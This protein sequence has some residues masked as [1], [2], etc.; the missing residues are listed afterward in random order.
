MQELS[1][2]EEAV[3]LWK[4]MSVSN[5][6]ATISDV[7]WSIA[8]LYQVIVFEKVAATGGNNV[9]SD[10]SAYVAALQKVKASTPNWNELTQEKKTELTQ[11]ELMKS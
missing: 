1:R 9:P 11:Q 5:R 4:R 6:Q 10:Q 3:K 8:N 7:E 2:G